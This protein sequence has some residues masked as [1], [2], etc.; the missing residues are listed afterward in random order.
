MHGPAEE[1]FETFGR[2]WRPK[3]TLRE[4]EK[5]FQHPYF[6]KRAMR[7]I[8]DAEE[9]EI[10]SLRPLDK[11]NWRDVQQELAAVGYAET[12]TERSAEHWARMY[13]MV[14][15]GYAGLNPVEQRDSRERLRERVR[16]RQRVKALGNRKH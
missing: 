12:P 8:N 3:P 13:P 5:Q 6:K 16:W 9:A 11:E 7:A 14:I 15:P 10:M 1:E 4:L 2:E